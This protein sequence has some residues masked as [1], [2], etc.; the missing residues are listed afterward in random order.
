MIRPVHLDDAQQLLDIYNYYVV[1]T[2]VTF[3]LEAVSL[4]SFKEKIRTISVDYPFIVFEEQQEV[5]GFAY[6]SRFR[7]KPAYNHTVEST[8]YIKHGHH[9]K[10]IGSLLYHDLLHLLKQKD[11]HIVLGVLTLP[12]EASV[13]LHE[14][15]GFQQVAFLNE[16]G[17]KFGSWQDVGFYQLMF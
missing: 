2:T 1:N 3:D 9:G 4:E 12:N 5:L 6:G 7:P 8:I 17:L 13:R 16:V 10:Q 11:F 15:F 14:K